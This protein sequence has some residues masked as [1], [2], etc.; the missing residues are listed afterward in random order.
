MI[1]DRF[2]RLRDTFFPSDPD[3]IDEAGVDG[4]SYVPPVVGPI[5]E[6]ERPPVNPPV[7]IYPP[8]DPYVPYEP[9]VFYPPEP[10]EPPLTIPTE[11]DIPIGGPD[12]I[13][14]PM[15]VP[16]VSGPIGEPEPPPIPLTIEPLYAANSIKIPVKITVATIPAPANRLFKVNINVKPAVPV[17]QNLVRKIG[18]SLRLVPIPLKLYS[19]VAAVARKLLDGKVEGFFDEDRE[20]KTI[21]NFGQDYQALVTNWMYDPS[22]TS[23]ASM[24]VKMYRPLPDEVEEKMQVWVARELAP[25][26][27]DRLF[28][29]YTPAAAPKIYLRPPNRKVQIAGRDGSSVSKVTMSN[30]LTSGAFNPV[31]PTDP[32]LEEWFTHDVNASELNVNYADYRE[33]VF[34]GSAQAR[35]NAFVNKLSIIE[36]LDGIIAKQSS[37]LATSGQI[38]TGS[39]PYPAIQKY[40]DQ[41]MEVIRSFDPYERFLYYGSETAY[42]SSLNT[43]DVDDAI[44]YNSD[45]TWPKISG[46]AASVTSSLGQTWFTSQ[47]VI[48]TEYDRQNQNALTNNIPTYLKNDSNSQEFTKFVDLVGHHFD[49]LKVYTDH[50]SRIYDRDSNPTTGMSQDLVWNVANSFGIKLPNQYSVRKLV[51]YTIGELQVASPKIYREVAA[52]TWK[53]FLHNQ[54]FLM[55]TKGTKAS[56]RALANT[57]GVLPNILR[58]KESTTLGPDSAP[59]FESYEEQTNVLNV[60]TGS[61]IQIPWNSLPSLP[62]TVQVRFATTIP[63][64]SVLLNA[65]NSWAV[66][67]EPTTGNYGKV[68]VR[69]FTQPEV[70][71]SVL[72]IFS[73]EFYSTM[74][75]Y[76]SDGITLHVARAEDDDIVDTSKTKET[77]TNIAAIFTAPTRLNVG[78]SGS[79]FALPNFTGLIDEVRVWGE[80]LSDAT[81]TQHTKYPGLYSG[82]TSTSARDSLFAR[83]SF[84]KTSNLGAT[85]TI[86]NEAPYVTAYDAPSLETFSAVGFQNVPTAPHNMSVVVR[87]VTRYTPN[88]ASNFTTNKVHIAEPPTLQYT[89]DADGTLVPVLTRDFSIKPLD[90]KMAQG[91]SGNTVGFYFSLTDSINDNIVR[92]VGNVDLQNLIGD[93]SDLYKLNYTALEQLNN[94][95]WNS[96]AYS[97]NVNSFVDFVQELLDPLFAQAR[98]LVPARAKLLSG[99]VHEPH[100]LERAKVVA[101]GPMQVDDDLTLEAA[102]VTSQPDNVEADY[103]PV[104]ATIVA[105]D[106][107]IATAETLD[108]AGLV[109]TRK[110]VL[111][112][113]DTSN[114]LA[115]VTG[116]SA[117]IVASSAQW[118]GVVASAGVLATIGAESLVYGADTLNASSVSIKNLMQS[119]TLKSPSAPI[120]TSITPIGP[121][122]D[123]TKLE[124]YT[125]FNTTN[126]LIATKAIVNVRVNNNILKDRGTW[127]K[128]TTY[129]RND[130]VVQNDPNPESQT[131]NGREW[132]C[133]APAGTIVS[134]IPPS[135]DSK[136]WQ[137]VRY[138]PTE[139][140]VVKKAV[141]INGSV[142][143]APMNSSYPRAV[144]YRPEHFKFTRDRRRGI[145][146]HQYAGCVQTDATTNDGKPAV[147]VFLTTGDVLL[148]NDGSAPVQP[149]NNPSGP[150]LDVL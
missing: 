73:G 146:N 54:I 145:I 85:G 103:V 51:D 35:L 148:V 63:S 91:T 33:F 93:P 4:D 141:V 134:L 14:P 82:E 105:V 113:A 22:D 40:A 17:F 7:T 124:S 135:L 26:V 81:F 36:D 123:F 41:R 132:V 42:S 28:V 83:L 72:P 44:Y 58:I 95:Y 122:T 79:A 11:P 118:D 57:Y 114:L 139:T 144:D 68:V 13:E 47:S 130:F 74:I 8:E 16:P 142:S 128:S 31:K 69:S 115:L 106:D 97:Y 100:I 34:F 46:S 117:E 76:E 1:F 149:K 111:P 48:A 102:P 3:R 60:T 32:I 39:L 10:I 143:L 24:L 29:T 138:V 30:L 53:R 15:E 137:P 147:E 99:I 61:H 92:S 110:N 20:G 75:R 121:V 80:T 112:K 126:S 49:I 21:L 52:E 2:R 50:M 56:L 62:K 64:S 107:S 119:A 125:Y 55:K 9:P 88:A 5:T 89:E 6:P 77:T 37:S 94:L 87:Q 78:G 43:E 27:V 45:A 25:P 104:S 66:T 59:N 108:H 131:G 120:D 109:D 127:A 70:S 116:S 101:Y 65:D 129:S 150:I 140:N 71:S 38:I 67:V 84:N 90:E 12:P 98:S 18:T 86:E 133:I 23:K 96:Y 136:N 19:A